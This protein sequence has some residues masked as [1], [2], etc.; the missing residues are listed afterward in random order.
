MMV[1]LNVPRRFFFVCASVVS[2]KTFV[3]S[4]FVPHL[5]LFSC[6]G[7]AATPNQ[8]ML[9]LPRK[10][11][12]DSTKDPIRRQ[13]SRYRNSISEGNSEMVQSRSTGFLRHQRRGGIMS[14]ETNITY[15]KK[16]CLNDKKVKRKVQGVP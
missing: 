1:F 4:L 11:C 14:V 2:C 8:K 16:E 7:R 10:F 3:L 9:P 12:E 5:S 13:D 6:L 15:D